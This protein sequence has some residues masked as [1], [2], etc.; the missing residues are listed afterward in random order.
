MGMFF[1]FILIYNYSEQK[2]MAKRGAKLNGS[3]QI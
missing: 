2:K 1:L 3:N